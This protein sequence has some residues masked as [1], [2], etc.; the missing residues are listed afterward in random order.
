MATGRAL[1]DVYVDPPAAQLA[2]LRAKG[3]ACDV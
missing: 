1:Q 3:C 2:I